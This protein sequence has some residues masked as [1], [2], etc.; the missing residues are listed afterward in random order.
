MINYY[1][2][3]YYYYY[4]QLFIGLPRLPVPHRC[5]CPSLPFFVY[6]AAIIFVLLY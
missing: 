1:Y 3:Y 4:Y 6:A 5:Y 2:Y